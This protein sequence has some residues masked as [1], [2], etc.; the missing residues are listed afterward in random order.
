MSNFDEAIQIILKH[1]GGFS[2]DHGNT[3]NFG[4]SKNFL[5][6]C[7]EEY[8]N[9]DSDWIKNLTQETAI[10]IY[11]KYFWL[12]NNYELIEDQKIAEKVFD[13]CVNCGSKTAN[14]CLQCAIN[15]FRNSLIED[16]ILGLKSLQE[17]EI[18]ATQFGRDALLKIFS[19]FATKFYI[20]VVQHKLEKREN[21]YGVFQKNC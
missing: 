13:L 7:T 5:H 17:L 18:V 19:F 4:I 14:R 15:S 12:P 1:E 2:E 6:T 3:T 21:L 8:I 20:E 11:K 9:I 10:A 16:G